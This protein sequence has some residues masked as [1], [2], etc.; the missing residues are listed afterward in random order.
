MT[1]HPLPRAARPGIVE[2]GRWIWR[3]P[4][5]LLVLTASLFGAN[6]VAARLATGQMSPMVLV[7]LRW[8]GVCLMLA[9]LLGAEQRDE[10][11][12][13]VRRHW[14]RLAWMALFGFSGYNAV[15]Y[16]AAYHTSAINLTLLQ[17]ATP[18][19]TLVGAAIVFGTR[20]RALQV[21][22]MLLTFFG[23]LIVA[24]KGDLEALSHLRL[25]AADAVLIGICAFYAA[26]ALGLRARPTC[27]A[28]V[29]FSGLALAA[30]AWSV[31]MATVEIA[32][33]H[34]YWPSLEGWLVVLFVAVG[35]SFAA[36]I[37]FLRGVDLIGPGRAGLA[38]NLVPVA[39][40]L[41]AVLVLHEPFT[42]AHAVALALGLGGVSL[43]E[44]SVARA[45]R[46]ERARAHIGP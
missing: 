39:G 40:A 17:S 25:G 16:L 15:F 18:P 12:A 14:R 22:G 19:F 24:A 23:V 8:L 1:D 26:Y 2:A 34:A 31:P 13:L 29:F 32:T 38:V 33:G 6:G 28:L 27:S 4:W 9:M 43:A 37:F 41:A 35:P 45:L 7:F 44:W 46:R 10:L 21:V 30:L 3:Q 42:R 11:R 36:Q 5:L 20:V